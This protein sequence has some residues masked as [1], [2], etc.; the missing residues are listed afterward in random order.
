MK[1][2][3]TFCTSLL[4][5]LICWQAKAQNL[6]L[7][8]TAAHSGGGATTYA[9]TN[10]NDNV[11]NACN[12]LPW[13]WVTTNGWIEYTWSTA[14]TINKVVFRKDNRP[15]TSC[16]IEYWNGTGYSTATNYSGSSCDDSI[17][18]SPVTTTKLRFNSVAG[19]SNPNHREIEVYGIVC[20]TKIDNQPSPV[21]L[22]EGEQAQFSI[23]ATDVTAYKWQVDEG[24][25]F[26]D[27]PNSSL[28]SGATTNTL[29]ISNTPFNLDNYQYRCLVS[30]GTSAT[31]ADTSNDVT[32]HVYGLVKAEPLAANDTTCINAAKDI[33]VTANGS[34][35][36]YRWQI[37]N[38]ITQQYED[39]TVQPPYIIMGNI[40]RITNAHDTLDG[41]KY[42]VLVDGICDSVASNE[43]R[44]TVLPIPTVA[45]HPEDV[46]TDPGKQ[47]TYEVQA[48]AAG[49]LYQWQVSPGT[50]VFSNINDGGI[51]Q[52]TRT[53]R[54][55]VLGVD[56]SQNEFR[57][58]CVVRTGS[59]CNA[60]GDTSSIAMLYVNPLVSVSGLGKDGSMVVFPNPTG[61]VLHI[62]TTGINNEMLKYR[63]VDKTGKTLVVGNLAIGSD[64]RVDVAKLAADIYILEILD[65]TGRNI[66]A[67]RFTKL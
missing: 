7:T 9:A 21:T 4:M 48:S 35:T 27:I 51:Y 40:L 64:T 46:T 5:A 14:Q 65:A 39:L 10:Y 55:I 25:G 59:A 15:M 24:S 3:F 58:R 2:I 36:N 50:G 23:T 42:R 33:K 54:L 45:V 26:N 56:R 44:L 22:C 17:T 12:N 41:A 52:G 11:Y 67:S 57:F 20:S 61:D 29:T 16:V 1:I 53:N 49:A 62:K 66:G 13:G 34:I 8:A 60:P 32:L 18:F 30:K 31:C 47:V 37:Y 63:I 28:Y 38:A 19:S 6:A 43:T